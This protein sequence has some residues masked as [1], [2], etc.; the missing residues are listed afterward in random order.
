M[1]GYEDER[2]NSENEMAGE[3]EHKRAKRWNRLNV[4][5][6]DRVAKTQEGRRERDIASIYYF[7]RK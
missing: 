3:S 7:T 5:E 4:K 1:E 2:A 6:R